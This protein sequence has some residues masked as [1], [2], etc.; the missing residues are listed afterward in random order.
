MTSDRPWRKA[1]SHA[2]AVKAIEEGAGSKWD[3]RLVKLFLAMI[4]KEA[5]SSKPAK[6]TNT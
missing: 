3:P 1:M 4:N 2:E 6:P 5:K